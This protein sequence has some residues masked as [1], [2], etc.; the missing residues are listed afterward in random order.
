MT[1]HPA[2]ADLGQ[3]EDAADK[4]L[5]EAGKLD[6]QTRYV[7]GALVGANDYLRSAL[8]RVIAGLPD[9]QPTW[10]RI[11][12]T[13]HTEHQW[14]PAT[15]WAGVPDGQAAGDPSAA[16]DPA[17]LALTRAMYPTYDNETEVYRQ[18][19]RVEA[20]AILRILDAGTVPGYGRLPSGPV[21]PA[22]PPYS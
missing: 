10:C 11:G 18:R 21:G 16:R 8:R 17:A 22:L 14:V 12:C 19:Y 4:A 6:P 3:A 7:I 9:A 2:I 15:T 1:E 20:D 13:E 5:R